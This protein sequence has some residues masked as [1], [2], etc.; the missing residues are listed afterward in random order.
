M[1]KLNEIVNIEQNVSDYDAT[2]PQDE[3]NDTL[4]NQ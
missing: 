1:D 3:E 4:T 2:A